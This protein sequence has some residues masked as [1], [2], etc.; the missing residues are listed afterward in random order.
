MVDDESG[1]EDFRIQVEVVDDSGRLLLDD[2]PYPE[3][4]TRAISL[5]SDDAIIGHDVRRLEARVAVDDDEVIHALHHA[6]YR[7]EGRLRQ[8]RVRENGWIDEYI[9]S[10]LA[11]DEIYTR[12]GH[13]LSLIHN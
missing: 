9:Y 7:R 4:L 1:S 3:G 2:P 8:A 6:G 13:T 12:T 5:A 11:T 10:R